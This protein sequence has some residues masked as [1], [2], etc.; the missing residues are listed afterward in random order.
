M[1]PL[2]K[3]EDHNYKPIDPKLVKLPPPQAPSEKLLKAVESFYAPPSHERPRDADGWEHG[4]L[5]EFFRIKQEAIKRAGKAK[6]FTETLKVEE[7]K[8]EN[9]EMQDSPPKRR[10]KEEKS[11]ERKKSSRRSKSGSP[12]SRSRSRRR[13][14]S[15]SSS[16]DSRSSSGSS[17]SRSR[18]PPRKRSSDRHSN[19]H[20]NRRSGSNSSR[21]QSRKRSRSPDEFKP[22][23]ATS[24]EMKDRNSKLEETNKGAQLLLKMGWSGTGGLGSSEQGISEPVSET[25]SVRDSGNMYHG[26]GV[27]EERSD[28]YE[29]YRKSR[30]QA[31]LDRISRTRDEKS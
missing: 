19:R 3:P 13:R 14:S 15:S 27:R 6:V 30:G 8:K 9:I 12:Q 20:H 25:G 24:F 28:A 18:S 17:R 22:S 5:A 29:S 21:Q 23:F 11:P 31:F 7:E 2:V 1:V 10:Y 26:I 4:A 16:N